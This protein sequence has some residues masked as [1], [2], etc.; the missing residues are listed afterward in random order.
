MAREE[1]L[2]LTPDPIGPPTKAAHCAAFFYPLSVEVLFPLYTQKNKSAD[3][4]EKGGQTPP[5]CV[6]YGFAAS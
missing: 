6:F 4:A 1:G 3:E 5:P 2:D